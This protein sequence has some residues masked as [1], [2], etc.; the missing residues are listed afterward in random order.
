MASS[1][2]CLSRMGAAMEKLL[3]YFE[4]ELGLLRRAGSAFAQRYPRLAGRL[5]INGDSC[6]D[7]HVERLIQS[8]AFLNARTAR[9]LDDGHALFTEALLSVLYP[10]LIRPLPSCS[11]ARVVDGKAAP[12]QANLLARGSELASAGKTASACRFRTAYDVPAAMPALTAL[13]F[14]PY[15]QPPPSVRLPVQ[16]ACGISMAVEGG[17]DAPLRLFIDGEASL[18]ATLR[19]TLF[20]RV[21]AAYVEADGG[22]QPLERNPIT[23]AGWQAD[24]A[25]LPARASEQAA[26]RLL[27]EYFAFPEKFNFVDL[28]MAALR[29][30]APDGGRLTVHLVLADLRPDSAA[31]RILRA[32]G[33]DNLLAGCTP[34][35]NLFRHHATPL[36]LPYTGSSHAL[37][38]DQLP[39]AGCDIYSVD[40]VQL[41]Y[42][43]GEAVRLLDFHPLHGMRHGGDG[44]SQGSSQ[45]NYYV[46]R[47]DAELAGVDGAHEYTMALA[48]PEFSPLRLRDGSVSVGLTCTNRDLPQSLPHGQ[49]GGDLGT[50]GGSASV[51][52]RLLR[53]PTAMSPRPEPGDAHWA[54]V[55]QL[56]L[57]HRNLTQ[58]GLPALLAMLRLYADP[59]NEVAQRQIGGIAALS[60][61]P[62]ASWLQLDGGRAYV[63]GVAIDVTLDEQAYAGTGLHVFAQLL[64]HYFGLH[65][66]LNSYTQLTIRSLQ[67]SKELLRCPP[68][69]GSL[70]LA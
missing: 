3:P 20:M 57:N 27:S 52:A 11:V 70:T 40:S 8:A 29:H 64:D 7:P 18:C 62:A 55:A 38:P 35:I 47:R 41:Q 54:L 30:A 60:H 21:A 37:M 28:D 69:N 9:L 19:D 2:A 58:E 24:D 16:A 44:N 26:Y 63:R 48:G 39:A 5:Q 53:R 50:V 10:H 25:L 32:L 61:R 56:A 12:G 13:R 42:K 59:D 46:L 33:P 34:V 31:A 1:A 49:P 66:H 6:A 4:R 22:W 36:R 17:G 65:V 67:T 45:G 14:E 68:R 51:K 43:D 15:L 23:P